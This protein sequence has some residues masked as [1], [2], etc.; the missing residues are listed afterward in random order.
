MEDYQRVANEL[1][2]KAASADRLA[3]LVASTQ[4]ELS[5]LDQLASEQAVT[6]Y[7]E[8]LVSPS[9]VRLSELVAG[10]G[11]GAKSDS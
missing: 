4:A 10:A 3:G 5:S 9:G 6:A 11:D 2:I 1:A 8:A 7:I